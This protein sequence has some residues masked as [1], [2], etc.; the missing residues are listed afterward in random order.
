M[1]KREDISGE[2]HLESSLGSDMGGDRRRVKFDESAASKGCLDD[3][4][5][6]SASFSSSF[7]ARKR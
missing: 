3:I 6:F 7:L 1:N 4:N 2:E 5:C